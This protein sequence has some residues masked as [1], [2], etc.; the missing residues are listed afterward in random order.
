MTNL[1]FTETTAKRL[2]P[3]LMNISRNLAKKRDEGEE[4]SILINSII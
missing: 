4:R 2:Y 1:G 3:E